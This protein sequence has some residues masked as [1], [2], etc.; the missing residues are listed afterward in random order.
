MRKITRFC[1]D[2]RA[3]IIHCRQ[4]LLS[5][6]DCSAKLHWHLQ[7]ICETGKTLILKGFKIVYFLVYCLKQL[8]WYC[9]WRLT[10]CTKTKPIIQMM[11]FNNCLLTFVILLL[12]YAN[13]SYCLSFKLLF[14]FEVG[15]KRILS[16]YI[17]II[18]IIRIRIRFFLC[19]DIADTDI[20]NYPYPPTPI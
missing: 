14:K 11:L 10:C 4:L 19:S 13:K 3:L 2:W 9:F 8:K 20:E 6:N 16:G 15:K 18:F 12:I 7:P 1:P 17:R 5:P